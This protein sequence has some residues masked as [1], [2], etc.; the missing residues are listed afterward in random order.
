MTSDLHPAVGG[1]PSTVNTGALCDTGRSVY[2]L[3]QRG[4]A[5]DRS[6]GSARWCPWLWSAFWM[7][8][9]LRGLSFV[10]DVGG[11]ES[12]MEVASWIAFGAVLID[13]TAKQSWNG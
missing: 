9:A 12:V 6:P 13:L 8:C 3:M 5:R 11:A 2:V 4:R 10:V 7:L 1:T